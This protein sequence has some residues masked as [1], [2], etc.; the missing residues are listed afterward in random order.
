VLTATLTYRHAG[1]SRTAKLRAR[2]VT[3]DANAALRYPLPARH[4]RRL[5]VGRRVTLRLR[6]RARPA[7]GGCA[8]GTPRTLK[9]RARVARV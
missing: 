9:L 4:A 2:D 3:T 5:D 8:Y 1:R 6:V 7:T